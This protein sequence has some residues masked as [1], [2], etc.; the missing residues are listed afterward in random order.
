MGKAWLNRWI[1]K[2]YRCCIPG[3]SRP[4]ANGFRTP[5]P[6]NPKKK[7]MQLTKKIPTKNKLTC[8]QKKKGLIRPFILYVDLLLLLLLVYI[9]V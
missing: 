2:P 9:K 8:D 3:L 1:W 6:Q 7:R 4:E 5:P